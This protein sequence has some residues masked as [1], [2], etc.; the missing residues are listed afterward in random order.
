[1]RLNS[2]RQITPDD[3]SV[4]ISNAIPC[5]LLFQS[6]SSAI[7]SWEIPC[8][9][10]TVS[11]ISVFFQY[12][13]LLFLYAFQALVGCSS[14]YRVT[15]YV[16]MQLMLIYTNA[17]VMFLLHL[18]VMVTVECIFVS[19]FLLMHGLTFFFFCYSAAM[20]SP[21]SAMTRCNL[22]LLLC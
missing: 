14:L 5:G 1:M 20:F 8:C 7:C 12:F 6:R 13:L 21:S 9:L 17:H 18:S 11:A 2:S 3:E 4:G 10:R 22:S 19:A 15:S 16:C